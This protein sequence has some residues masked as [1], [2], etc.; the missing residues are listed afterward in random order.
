[1]VSLSRLLPLPSFLITPQNKA[2]V[3]GSPCLQHQAQPSCEDQDGTNV[4]S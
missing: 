1:M 4:L 2:H 3:T